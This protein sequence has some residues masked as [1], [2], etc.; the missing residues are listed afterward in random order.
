MLLIS[1]PDYSWDAGVFFSW[2]SLV[3]EFAV[4][5]GLTLYCHQTCFYK[6]A[7]VHVHVHVY[8]T[9]VAEFEHKNEQRLYLL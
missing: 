2:I 4:S 9:I 1:V 7:N 8:M 3:L 5:N 6:S